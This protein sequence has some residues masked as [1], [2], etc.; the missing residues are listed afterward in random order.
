MAEAQSGV[1]FAAL[2]AEREARR[3]VPEP[4]K[5][6]GG[7]L[8]A[9]WAASAQ[10]RPNALLSAH[11]TIRLGRAIGLAACALSLLLLALGVGWRVAVVCLLLAVGFSRAGAAVLHGLLPPTLIEAGAKPPTDAEIA[12]SSS[13]GLFCVDGVKNFG[14]SL[15]AEYDLAL[16]SLA[17]VCTYG[18]K[19]CLT[20]KM[21]HG[22]ITLGKIV[23]LVVGKLREGVVQC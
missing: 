17:F 16:D 2:R 11:R 5:A 15:S 13:M 22:P 19:N 18:K 8:P 4:A 7:P 3:G 20:D 9:S 21:Y 14:A 1:D 6:K 12:T 10:P 23:G